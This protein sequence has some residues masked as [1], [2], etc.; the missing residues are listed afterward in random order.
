MGHF[1]EAEELALIQKHYEQGTFVDIGANIGNHSLYLSK[2]GRCPRI[3]VFEPNKAAVDVLRANVLLNRCAN[4]DTRYLG[5]ALA[6]SDGRYRGVTPEPNNLGHTIFQQDP[7]GEVL[8]VTGD[9]LLL[10]EPI[11]FIKIDVEGMEFEIL[12]GLA[13]TICR[14]RPKLF[15]EVWDSRIDEF[16]NWCEVASYVVVD[17]FR[18]YKEIENFLVAPNVGIAKEPPAHRVAP[19]ETDTAASI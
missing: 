2:F 18:R 6:A 7:A 17:R 15:I 5:V 16:T 4:I 10:G 12:R 14:W 8:G 9:S 13:Q 11:G 19:D 1:Y 3:L